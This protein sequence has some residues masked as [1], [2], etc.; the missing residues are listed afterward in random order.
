MKR[1]LLL[2][3][4]CSCLPLSVLQ[5]RQ[6][7]SV[8]RPANP[9]PPA[10]RNSAY[11][12]AVA[13]ARALAAQKEFKAATTASEQAIQMDDKRWEGYVVAAEA[14]SGQQLYDDAIGMLQ[15][16]LVRTPEEKKPAIRQAI[17]ETRRLLSGQTSAPAIVPTPSAAPSA[18]SAPTP[19][20]APTQAEIILWKGIENSKSASD[21]QAYLDAYPNGVYAP[22]ANRRLQDLGQPVK[23]A[24]K[25]KET[26]KELLLWVQDNAVRNSVFDIT[27]INGCV[28]SYLAPPTM[29]NGAVRP[30]TTTASI[31]LMKQ[32]SSSIVLM[33]G[34]LTSD[35]KGFWI[36]RI[37]KVS[38]EGG[39]LPFKDRTTAGDAVAKLIEAT[40]LCQTKH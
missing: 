35:Y 13:K 32:D 18:A 11:D 34:E 38:G 6:E 8:P 19:A 3:L 1:S 26:I 39:A 33:P 10:R 27:T 20:T 28:I 21:Y 7:P 15:M 14:Y 40:E 25:T 17:T 22:L 29:W 2:I 12:D 31:D 4:I 37:G 30:T 24:T 5:A 23:D 36:A 16:A 9:A